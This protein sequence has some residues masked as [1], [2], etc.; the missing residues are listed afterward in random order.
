MYPSHPLTL[1]CL[2]VTDFSTHTDKEAKEVADK[3]KAEK[4]AAAD[5]EK[6]A[7]GDAASPSASASGDGAA[8]PSKKPDSK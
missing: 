8:T 1:S 3:E 2:V 6:A 4:K 7:G 5:K